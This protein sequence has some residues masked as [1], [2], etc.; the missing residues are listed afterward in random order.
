M[1]Q[2]N[3]PVPFGAGLRRTALAA[4]LAALA[5]PSPAQAAV[6]DASAGGFEVEN[7]V[8]V[9]ASPASA[10]AMLGR[11]G[12]WWA[13]EHTY[14][15]DARNLS[16]ALRAGG[17]FCERLPNGGSVEHL[18][19]VYADPGRML[20]LQGGLGPLQGEGVAGSLTFTLKAVPQGTEIV[21][22]YIV[23]GYLRTSDA[24]LAP[25]LDRVLAGQLERLAARLR[26]GR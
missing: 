2:L 9:A 4:M 13:P 18:R 17:C 19:V 21:M 20:R 16:L 10:Y 22:N 3:A 14:S 6:K 1:H 25:I 26:Q 5:A 8:V 12:E 11:P 15:H 23:G 24:N 7:R